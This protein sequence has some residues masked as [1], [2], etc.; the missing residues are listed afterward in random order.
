MAKA[1][2]ETTKVLNMSTAVIGLR[3]FRRAVKEVIDESGTTGEDL[4]KAANWRVAQYIVEKSQARAAT[5]GRLQVRAA[6]SM[7]ASKRGD[8]AEVFA[9]VSKDNP[10]FFGAEF[11]AKQNILRK[12]RRAAGWAGPGRY[13]GYRQFPIWKKPGGGN[14]GY[15]LFPTLREES[16][17]VVEMYGEE[18]DKIMKSVFPEQVNG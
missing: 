16:P 9:N 1:K 7:K 5:V 4:L 6:E 14:T 17:R 11:G 12:P 3:D 18:L 15:F 10:F 2:V 13:R 8:R